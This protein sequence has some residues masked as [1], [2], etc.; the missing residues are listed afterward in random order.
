ML[1][2]GQ[3]GRRR[4]ESLSISL[5]PPCIDCSFQRYET[6]A[7][8][9][10]KKSNFKSISGKLWLVRRLGICS[11]PPWPRR[12]IGTTRCFLGA[13]AGASRGCAGKGR[14]FGPV[15]RVFVRYN[16]VCNNMRYAFHTS[17]L[18]VSHFPPHLHDRCRCRCGGGRRRGGAA[19]GLLV[20]LLLD[21]VLLSKMKLSHQHNSFSHKKCKLIF[22]LIPSLI[23]SLWYSSFSLFF[24]RSSSY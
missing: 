19:L 6:S 5:S 18:E 4:Y 7:L 23:F 22:H 20:A 15:S 1:S 10:Q 8:S 17:T 9:P 16:C 11:L 2:P 3:I 13:G 24:R 21:A 14:R 12:A